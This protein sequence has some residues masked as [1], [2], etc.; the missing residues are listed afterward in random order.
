M[1]KKALLSSI[2]TIALCLSLISGA[3][4]ALFT[5]ESQTNIAVTSGTVKLTATIGE[6]SLYT[7]KAISESGVITNAQNIAGTNTF[8]NAGGT[9][10]LTENRLALTNMVAGDKANAKIFL[11]NESNIA[12]QYR[13]IVKSVG[14]DNTLFEALKIT[15]GEEGNAT[16]F[17][18]NTIKSAWTPLSV[19]ANLTV[20]VSVELP[21]TTGNA[22]QGKSCELAFTVEAVQ[23]NAEMPD[24]WNG[25][26][27]EAPENP[28][29]WPENE[30]HI[31]TAAQ[32]I[33]AMNRTNA[34]GSNS[35][36]LGKT[37][38]LDRDIDLGGATIA[39]FGSDNDN[40]S[41]TFD[42]KNHTISNFVIDNSLDYYSGLFNQL[43]HG[44]II[45]NLRV[46]NA[47]VI[48]K[49]MV[50]VIASNV[51]NATI[52]NCHVTNSTVIANEKKAG[53]ITGY[54]AGGTVKNCT[55]TNVN[56]FCANNESGEIVGYVNAGSTVTGNTAT[57]VSV[58]RGVA[59]VITNAAQFMEY[60]TE[61][62]HN[63]SQGAHR[64]DEVNVV[65]ISDIDLGGA[66]LTV[67]GEGYAFTGSFDGM[68]HTISN[69]TVK[70]TDG[71]RYTGLFSVYAQGG[72]T[73]KNL[74]VKNGTVHSNGKQVS[75][76]MPAVYGNA[77]MENCH[78]INC[79]VTSI[80]KVGAITSI[81]ETGGTV[82]NCTAS[83]NT[84]ITSST[85]DPVEATV[86]GFENGGTFTDNNQTGTNTIYT[87]T[88]AVSTAEELKSAL[89]QDGATV[90]LLNDI[91][92]SEAWTPVAVEHDEYSFAQSISV[93]GNGHT[94]FGLTAPL[95]AGNTAKDITI[96]NL[97]IANSNIA[98]GFEN[99]EGRGAFIAY[100]DN[101]NTGMLTMTNCHLKNSTV[102][103][104]EGAGAL[105]G[106]VGQNNVTIQNCSA[107]DCTI[108]GKNVGGLVGFYMT[109][110]NK[111][112]MIEKSTV[113]GCT[114]TGTYVG[115][116]AGTVNNNGTLTIKNCTFSGEAVGR[117]SDTTT[118]NV[119]T[120]NN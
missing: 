120:G 84:I 106:Y 88:M 19:G 22:Y 57:N 104:T 72:G 105:I 91:T 60:I 21:A 30:Y 8:G 4:F 17:N 66:V 111:T 59:K 99:G 87:G 109:D 41:F 77:T 52:E 80:G 103:A 74:T 18:G 23:G 90:Y 71:A 5:G 46:D 113:S 95:L 25:T 55:A 54:T 43:S 86:F 27:T 85:E 102:T 50:G 68:N 64:Y 94:I 14:E 75:A 10:A 58:R 67:S 115:Q 118:V 11:T 69:Y 101:T 1:K 79:T 45:K 15:L 73:I 56:V 42:G 63:P 3:S 61:L 28:N 119:V 96:S 110:A 7:P 114:L 100:R 47:T 32:L 82:K 34:G 20:P 31:S 9:A 78:A 2:L 116:I 13:V 44:G 39:G 53:A 107:T 12:I 65:L 51:D 36:A 70:R 37:I 40:I 89:K 97:T 48:G 26:S 24:E 112:G 35:W 6:L 108:T 38:V 29:E 33:G 76:I 83:G 49:S 62:N 117:R 92:L 81:C 93:E 98:S 16:V